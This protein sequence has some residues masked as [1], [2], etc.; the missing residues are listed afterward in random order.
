MHS[1]RGWYDP[2][3]G[4]GRDEARLHGRRRYDPKDGGDRAKQEA[5]AENGSG[6]SVEEARA[7]SNT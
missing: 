1:R 7:Q 4:V 5:R 2:I 3:D 6:D